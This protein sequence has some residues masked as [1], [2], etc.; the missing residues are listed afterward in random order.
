MTKSAIFK[1]AHIIARMTA[2]QAGSYRIAFSVALKDIYAGVY[3]VSFEQMLNECS[4][5]LYKAGAN[6]FYTSRRGDKVCYFNNAAERMGYEKS[7]AVRDASIRIGDAPSK[8]VN[9]FV[10]WMYA[11]SF[12]AE[13]AVNRANLENANRTSRYDDVEDALS[14]GWKAYQTA[15]NRSSRREDRV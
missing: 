11:N 9:R 7:E 6:P 12:A 8:A 3:N 15:C 10:V 5:I 14:F 13:A 2:K 1:K 4:G